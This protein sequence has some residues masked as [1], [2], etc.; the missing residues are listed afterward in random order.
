MINIK[1]LIIS[2]IL[3]MCIAWPYSVSAKTKVS[4]SEFA[5]AMAHPFIAIKA[6]KISKRVIYITDSLEAAGVLKDRSGGQLDAFKHA[7]WMASLSQQI[8]KK[9]AY[10]L[11]L[12]HEKFN[13][14]QAKKGKGGGDKAAS[15]MDL[16]NNRV[17]ASLGFD[18]RQ[19]SES[20]LIELV[21][22]WVLQG[23]MRVIK[24]DAQG[25]SLDSNGQLIDKL[26]LKTW[27]NKRCLVPSDYRYNE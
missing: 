10:K 17:G 26:T 25:N 3:I 14:R 8:K 24:K 23:K 18:N 20:A 2:V 11:G 27:V 16:W 5:W 21:I 22:N 9:K 12:A 1:G 13:F 7:F 6:K 4:G 19:L 15:D